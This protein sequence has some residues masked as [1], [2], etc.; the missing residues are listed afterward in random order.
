[1]VTPGDSWSFADPCLLTGEARQISAWLP[2]GAAGTVGVTGP[3]AEGWL[4]PNTWFVEP[5]LALSLADRDGQGAVI[6]VHLC[7]EVAPRREQGDDSADI[8]QYFVEV[9]MS[10]ETLLHEADQ[11]DLALDAFPAR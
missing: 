11:R 2:S 5:V 7:L 1:V 3:D 6:R 10:E 9:H 4:S 8:H